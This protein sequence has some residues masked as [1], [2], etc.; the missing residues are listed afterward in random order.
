M[1]LVIV[2]GRSGSGKSVA[3]RVLEDLGYY[4]VDNLPLS[5][6][7]SLLSELQVSNDKIAI[8]VDVRNLPEQEKLLE[9]ELRKLPNSTVIKSMFL[10]SSDQVLLKRYSETRR[11]H[12]LSKSQS[13]LSDAIKREGELLAPLS[14]IMDHFIDTSNLTIYELSDKVRE[15]LLG[16]V[17][18]ELVITFESFGFKHGMPTE[19]DFMFDVRFLPNPHWEQELRPLTGLDAPVQEFLG[20]Q[21]QVNKF[22]WQ[23]ESLLGTW[24]PQ[25]ERNNRS[26]LTIAIGCTGGQHRSVYVADQLAKRFTN[27][28]HTVQ[29]R[30][31]ELNNASA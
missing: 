12:P 13:S 23:I 6:I 17:E 21:V 31:R 27:G 11:L 24:L 4:C 19:A 15:I 16:R 26:Y 3:L 5:L 8:S 30:H 14:K 2:S 9:Q 25:L 28:K 10:N 22:I 29:S 18:K 1:K 20:R 7:G